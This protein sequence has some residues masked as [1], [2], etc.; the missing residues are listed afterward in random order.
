MGSIYT[1]LLEGNKYYVGITNNLSKRL[2]QHFSG[3][4]SAWTSMYKPIK[5]IE[6]IENCD[7]FDED[8]YTKIYM[9]KYGIDNVRG[10][11]YSTIDLSSNVKKMLL[12]EF[13]TIDNKCFICERVGHF[14]KNCIMNDIPKLNH[15][16]ELI[17]ERYSSIKQQ[18]I[19]YK[20]LN[21]LTK[22][23]KTE[24]N[25][26]RRG[27]KS[28]AL[29]KEFVNDTSNYI[30]ETI[31]KRSEK[32]QG[33][34]VQAD[35]NGKIWFIPESFHHDFQY[36]SCPFDSPC[37][38]YQCFCKKDY[39]DPNLCN[40]PWRVANGLFHKY[41]A[42]SIFDINNFAQLEMYL[43]EDLNKALTRLREIHD[44]EPKELLIQEGSKLITEKNE[45][46][47]FICK[48]YIE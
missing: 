12:K 29:A 7:V 36:Q 15:K 14:A 34:R 31:H 22:E 42:G 27:K 16:L 1:L 6:T 17:D 18:L 35:K 48:D 47:E 19:I 39:T 24:I 4:G 33:C 40:S 41:N 20:N 38:L 21:T 44:L 5:H 13:N 10:G 11:S 25:S 46:L 45:I 2:T 3:I 28:V 43:M 8:K 23:L 32:R 30:H 9:H 26:L 37:G